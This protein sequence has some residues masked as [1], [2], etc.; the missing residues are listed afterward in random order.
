MTVA[1]QPAPTY[2][3]E[4]GS[5]AVI[6]EAPRLDMEG[7]RIGTLRSGP[8]GPPRKLIYRSIC[9]RHVALGATFAVDATGSQPCDPP[10][11]PSAEGSKEA[12]PSSASSALR[13]NSA[14]LRSTASDT[15]A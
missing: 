3:V 9:Q 5:R 8:G 12:A 10:G 7:L 11:E 6:L 2:A 4:A 15:A 13:S 14:G 1:R